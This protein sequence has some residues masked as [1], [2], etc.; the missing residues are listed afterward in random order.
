L[1]DFGNFKGRQVCSVYVGPSCWYRWLGV[2]GF[3]AS[4]V[5]DYGCVRVN[6]EGEVDGNFVWGGGWWV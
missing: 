3:A 4:L 1:L 6:G 5:E 2:L